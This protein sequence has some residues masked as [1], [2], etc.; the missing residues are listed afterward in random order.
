MNFEN[1]FKADVNKKSPEQ[2]LSPQERMKREEENF[3]QHARNCGIAT[4]HA[5]TKKLPAAEI[6]AIHEVEG[7]NFETSVLAQGFIVCG[8]NV[9]GGSRDGREPIATPTAYIQII[10]RDLKNWEQERD[11]I[12]ALSDEEI[13]QR[14]AGKKYTSSVDGQEYDLTLNN[15]K[16]HLHPTMKSSYEIAVDSMKE[17]LTAFGKTAMRFEDYQTAKQALEVSGGLEKMT[18]AEKEQL[19]NGLKAREQA[20]KERLSQEIEAY[21]QHAKNCGVAAYQEFTKKVPAAEMEKIFQAEGHHVENV[22]RRFGFIPCGINSNVGSVNGDSPI[23]TIPKYI[24]TLSAEIKKYQQ[25]YEKAGVLSPETIQKSIAGR[26][27]VSEIDGQKHELNMDNYKYHS[28][29][30]MKEDLGLLL[31]RMK[32]T[33]RA[34]GETA[35]RFGD[36]ET[37]NLADRALAEL[38]K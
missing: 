29:F 20:D 24:E 11:G 31:I 1:F 26:T 2:A 21:F 10:K 35:Q 14:I 16:Y 36:Q 25:E 32:T 13:A 17:T 8:N 18:P 7:N 6:A 30:S 5:F 38:E 9:V 23:H 33:L 19:E 27:Y 12:P 28:S 22:V 37:A 3:W 34:F 4:Y 15:Y